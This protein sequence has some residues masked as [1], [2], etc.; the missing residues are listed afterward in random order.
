MIT[1]VYLLAAGRGRR[2]GGPKA[3]MEHEGRP[4]LARHMDF[5]LAVCPPDKIA[6]SIQEEWLERCRALHPEALWMPVDPDA[7]PLA[8]LQALLKRSP[9]QYWG[10]VFHVDMPLWD[11]ELF[12]ALAAAAPEAEAAGELAVIPRRE[13]RRGHPVLLSPKVQKPILALDP[14]RDR[15]DLWL[16]ANPV[17]YAEVSSP[18]SRENWNTPKDTAS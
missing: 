10:F 17:R 1:Q 6:V 8:S 13:G 16:S 7:A 15:L 14:A 5:L 11:K 2:M 12:D 3:W 18:R 4:L 9:L